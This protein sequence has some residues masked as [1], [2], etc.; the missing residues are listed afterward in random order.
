MCKFTRPIELR[1]LRLTQ[2]LGRQLRFI[3]RF[4]G[5]L[6]NRLR[7]RL[8]ENRGVPLGGAHFDRL[9]LLSSVD[10][11]GRCQR[12]LCQVFFRDAQ[13]VPDRGLQ[14]GQL[15]WGDYADRLLSGVVLLDQAGRQGVLGLR[16][17]CRG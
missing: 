13:F 1:R 8:H 10:G 14:I 2:H 12:C 6:Y 4:P 3:H 7:W 15:R 5:N 16:Q 9:H 11:Q 17:H